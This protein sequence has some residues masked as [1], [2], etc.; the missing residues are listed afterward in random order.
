MCFKIS[1][2]IFKIL[3]FQNSKIPNIQ[4][5][6]GIE[7][8]KYGMKRKLI[9]DK[10]VNIGNMNILGILGITYIHSPIYNILE[11]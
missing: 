4:I 9:I 7:I 10:K 3:K 11:P 1:S 2:N 8:L 5:M 6:N